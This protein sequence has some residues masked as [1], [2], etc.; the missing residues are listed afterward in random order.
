[1][2]QNKLVNSFFPCETDIPEQYRIKQPIQQQEYLINGEIRR[3]EGPC[4]Q[5]VSPIQVLREG[6]LQPVVLGCYPVLTEQEALAALDAAERA[7]DNGGGLW[8]TMSVEKRIRHMEL[9]TRNMIAK[10]EEVVKLLMWEIGKTLADS[11]KEFDRT[12]EYIRDTLEALKVLD[13]ESSRFTIEEGILAQIRRAPLGVVL[14]MGPYNYPLNETFTTLIPALVMG[15]TV[16]FKPPKLGVLLHSPLLEAFRAAFPPGVVN[17]VYGSG[18]KVVGPIMRSGKINTL[19]FIG[20]ST[21]AV[22]LKQQH[23]K[24]HRLRSVLGLEAKNAAIVL[25]DAAL[26][27]VVE[28]T[29]AGSLAYNGQ[30]C[31][32]LKI[33]FVHNRIIDEFIKRFAGKVSSLKL[34]MP[35]EPGVKITPLPEPNKSRYLQELIED[36]V[37]H[38]A[39]VI[40]PDGGTSAGSLFK[41]AVLYPVNEKMR[42]YSEEQFGPVVPIA[43]YD[44]IREPIQYIIDSNYGQQVSLFGTD[45]DL[46]ASLIDP[47]VNQVCRVNINSQCQRGPDRFPFTGRKDSAE[48]TLS[49]T[50]ALRV[51]SIRTMVAAKMTPANKQLIT[52]IVK[53]DK[54]KFLSTDFLL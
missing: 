29:L 46:M 41:P 43:G 11:E 3:W 25:A 31:T 15:N 33:L 21:V 9:F 40:N 30:R 17:T 2:G 5:V 38:G 12:V 36:A 50:D 13:R 14:C 20:S 1:M 35:W 28:E 8:P 22:T 4:Q 7:Y 44:D 34:G 24:P 19:A 23:P 51:F 39:T 53:G 32:A 16:V 49:V 54:S 10:R 37:K 42:V 26:D 18:Q 45:A 6:T 27:Q 52:D 47:L 48:G